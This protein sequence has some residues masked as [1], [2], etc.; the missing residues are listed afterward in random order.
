MNLAS[1]LLYLRVQSRRSSQTS[2]CVSL[3][4]GQLT[5]VGNA[6]HH[7]C[8][9]HQIALFTVFLIRVGLVT[10]FYYRV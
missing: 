2:K 4:K 8:Q 3:V 7:I 1:L 9:I 6:L 10:I 5:D